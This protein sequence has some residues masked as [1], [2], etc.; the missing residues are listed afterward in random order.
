MPD[1]DSIF[2]LLAEGQTP[3]SGESLWLQQRGV[4]LRYHKLSPYK[5]VKHLYAAGFTPGQIVELVSAM[6]VEDVDA[7]LT[8]VPFTV[9]QIVSLNAQGATVLEISKMLGIPRTT[10]YYHLDDLGIEPNRKRAREISLSQ[11]RRVEQLAD[12][13]LPYRV[14]AERVGLTY[15]QVRA[16]VRRAR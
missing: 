14:I 1:H 15:D 6:A 11:Q 8:Q 10:V 13:D 5:Q 12:M 3:T 4:P 9:P 16:A 2:E 7:E